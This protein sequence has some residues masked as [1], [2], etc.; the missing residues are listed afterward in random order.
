MIVL[1]TLWI[2]LMLHKYTIF[3]IT[4]ALSQ[5]VFAASGDYQS[6]FSLRQNNIST[7]EYDYSITAVSGFYYLERIKPKGYL[8]GRRHICNALHELTGV[9]RVQNIRA[10]SI[11]IAIAI[12]IRCRTAGPIAIPHLRILFP[13]QIVIPA[14]PTT[15]EPKSV[16]L[17]IKAM[18]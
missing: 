13:G 10:T 4:L 18:D 9:W 6:G 14:I 2:N 5:S 11:M 7:T 12:V 8:W 16:T 3:V 15:P 1:L 17:T